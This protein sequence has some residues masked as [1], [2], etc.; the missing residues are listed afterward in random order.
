MK[1][2]DLADTMLVGLKWHPNLTWLNVA[3]GIAN[4]DVGSLLKF[5]CKLRARM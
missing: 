5:M 3:L 2:G 4:F 1:Y